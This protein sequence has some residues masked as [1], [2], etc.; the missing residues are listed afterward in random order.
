MHKNIKQ[1]SNCLRRQ[2]I[3]LFLQFDIYLV[4]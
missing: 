1:T 2:V 4:F 3:L